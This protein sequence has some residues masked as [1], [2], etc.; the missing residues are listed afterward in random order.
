M[1]RPWE[2]WPFIS[3]ANATGGAGSGGAFHAVGTP[4]RRRRP[5]R[6]GC[7]RRQVLPHGMGLVI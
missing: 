7:R 6:R 4:C 5:G 1:R 2:D 3:H